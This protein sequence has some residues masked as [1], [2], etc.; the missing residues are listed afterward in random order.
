VHHDWCDDLFDHWSDEWH[1]LH[2]HCD[3]EERQWHFSGLGGFGWCSSIDG[4]ERPAPRD[5]NFELERSVGG[6]MV[7]LNEYWRCG[8]HGLHGDIIAGCEHLHHYGCHDMH[9]CWSDER[10]EL[11]IHGHCLEPQRHLG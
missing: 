9:C 10:Y 5:C 8:D 11:H 7:S 4:P 1:E 3:R 2:I 6:V